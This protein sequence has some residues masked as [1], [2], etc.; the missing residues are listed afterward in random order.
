MSINDWT[1]SSRSWTVLTESINLPPHMVEGIAASQPYTQIVFIDR[2][3]ILGAVLFEGY[4]GVNGAV[5]MHANGD[6]AG[7]LRPGMVK[8]ALRYAFQFLDVR[9]IICEVSSS[10]GPANSYS[11][12]LGGRHIYTIEGY[13]PDADLNVYSIER[14]KSPVWRRIRRSLADGKAK[15]AGRTPLGRIA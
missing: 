7:W 4:T 14:D 12:R 13:F 6:D 10:N 15:Q 1:T 8:V 9:Q 11:K 5:S 2:K 3:R